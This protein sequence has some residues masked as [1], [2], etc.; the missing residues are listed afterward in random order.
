[1]DDNTARQNDD[2]VASRLEKL[3]SANKRLESML[4]VHDHEDRE[5]FEEI[6]RQLA[7]TTATHTRRLSHKLAWQEIA[8]YGRMV[9]IIGA[10]WLS[11]GHTPG[12][13]IKAIMELI[14]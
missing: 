11:A 3:E 12:E 2:T 6:S 14:Q 4:T 5:R 9:L 10:L 8:A 13:L 7:D 1:M